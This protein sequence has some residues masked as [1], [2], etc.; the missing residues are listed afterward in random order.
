MA[1]QPKSIDEY[2]ATVSSDKRHALN[3][4]RKVIQMAAPTAEEGFSYGLAAFRLNGKPL[5][6]FGATAKHCAFFPMDGTTVAA[7]K[8]ELKDFST[9]KGTIRFQPDKPLPARLVT[10]IVKARVKAI[11]ETFN[12]DRQLPDPAVT[13]FLNKLKHPHKKEMETVR[14]L[15]L[16]VSPKICEGI[17][18]NSMSF[19]TSEYFATLNWRAKDCV[20]FVFHTGAKVKPRAKP[21]KIADPSGLIQWLA[22]DRCL[23]TLGK[24]ADIAK[25]KKALCAIVRSWIRQL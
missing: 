19:R 18:W 13:E 5:V 4:L 1:S 3:Q 16:S 24:G 8:N 17:K 7:H 25:N 6:A 14:N 15:I 11:T 10:K 12:G 2:M 20:Q 23:I 21:L 22:K 9:S